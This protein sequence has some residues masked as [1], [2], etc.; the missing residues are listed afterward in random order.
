M[1]R[2]NWLWN[3]PLGPKRRWLGNS[4]GWVGKLVENWQVG[5]LYNVFAGTP[6]SW[7]SEVSSFNNV[8]DDTSVDSIAGISR[9]GKI[10]KRGNGVFFYPG[11]SVKTDPYVASLTTSGGVQQRSTL[12]AVFDAGGRAVATNPRPGTLGALQPRYFYGP[13]YFSL[14][15]NL[16]KTFTLRERVQL[17]FGVTADNVTN[18]PI[19]DDPNIVINSPTFGQI[20]GSAGSRVVILSGRITF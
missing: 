4:G 7:E 3:L 15:M 18:T 19:F 1:F 11:Y 5:A 12:L 2:S 10:E 20:T 13:G 9:K 16:L 14:D 8:S 17:Q 6:M